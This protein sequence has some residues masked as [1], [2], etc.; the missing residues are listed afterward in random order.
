MH[1][2][3]AMKSFDKCVM[4]PDGNTYYLNQLGKRHVAKNVQRSHFGVM[5]EEMSKTLDMILGPHVFNKE[6]E[7]VWEKFYAKMLEALLKHVNK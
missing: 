6:A 3:V 4:D 2:V 5:G 1:V 7:E